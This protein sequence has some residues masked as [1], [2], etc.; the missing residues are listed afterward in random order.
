[1]EDDSSNNENTYWYHLSSVSECSG[2]VLYPFW[3]FNYSPLSFRETKA[4]EV[5]ICPRTNL[6]EMNSLNVA[7]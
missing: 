4:Q 1:M 6:A 3:F 2:K 7:I 5:K